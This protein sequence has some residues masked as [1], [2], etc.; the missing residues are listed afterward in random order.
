MD[1][2]VIGAVMRKLPNAGPQRLGT[3]SDDLDLEWLE[4]QR[5]EIIT[6]SCYGENGTGRKQPRSLNEALL[7]RTLQLDVGETASVRS[8]R[9]LRRVTGFQTF[10]SA[11]A[12]RPAPEAAVRRSRRSDARGRR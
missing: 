10:G 6:R 11:C 4:I 8:L 5:I 2:D 7:D 12:T 3:V 9:H 1:L